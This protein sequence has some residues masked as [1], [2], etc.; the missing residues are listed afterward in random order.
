MINIGF[1]MKFSASR[2]LGPQTLSLSPSGGSEDR[3]CSMHDRDKAEDD[4]DERETRATIAEKPDGRRLRRRLTNP[5]RKNHQASEPMNTPETSRAPSPVVPSS[6]QT[7][8]RKDGRKGQNGRR[9]RNG[10]QKGRHGG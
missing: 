8:P 7:E 9:V 4:Q 3:Q 5:L 1:P 2:W 6:G 10:E